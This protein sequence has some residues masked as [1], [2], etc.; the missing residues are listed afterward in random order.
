MESTDIAQV[1]LTSHNR[2]TFEE[3][4]EM[5]PFMDSKDILNILKQSN[6]EIKGEQLMLFA[7]FIDSDELSD[8][9]IEI[10]ERKTLWCQTTFLYF[11]LLK[12]MQF[13]YC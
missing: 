9:I 11:H 5:A 8:W 2:F 4:S 7:P 13:K 3:I 1:I 10:S 6:T 12:K